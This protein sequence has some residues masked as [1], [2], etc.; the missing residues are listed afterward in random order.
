MFQYL[1][2]QF[3]DTR[4]ANQLCYKLN[5]NINS[6]VAMYVASDLKDYNPIQKDQVVTGLLQPCLACHMSGT[7]L[8][9]RQQGI[10]RVYT[11]FPLI[12]YYC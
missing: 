8:Y 10:P 2:T 7:K 11:D 9:N 4:R 5:G 6:Q 1:C 3:A 12:N